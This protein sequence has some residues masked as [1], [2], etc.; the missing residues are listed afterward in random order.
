MENN[1]ICALIK[2]KND[3]D[4]ILDRLILLSKYV[5]DYIIQDFNSSDDTPYICNRFL[6]III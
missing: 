3:A 2:T 5:N 1:K 6:N 4:I